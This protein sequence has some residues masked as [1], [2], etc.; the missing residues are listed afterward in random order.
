M[1]EACDGKAWLH[2]LHVG[3]EIFSRIDRQNEALAMPNKGFSFFAVDDDM[4]QRISNFPPLASPFGE[5]KLAGNAQILFN[6]KIGSV[7]LILFRIFDRKN[8]KE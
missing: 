3:M 1:V 2:A 6:A 8:G 7:N 5:Y 4:L